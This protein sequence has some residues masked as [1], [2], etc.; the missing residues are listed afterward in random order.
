MAKATK[1]A[2]QVLDN[3]AAVDAF[4][5]KLEHPLKAEMA[6]VRAIILKANRQVTE[7]VEWGAPSFYYKGDMAVFKLTSTMGP[8][9]WRATTKTDA[10]RTSPI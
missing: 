9:C 4:M 5:K 7:G 1:G 3:P 8:D 2:P 6:A 10:W